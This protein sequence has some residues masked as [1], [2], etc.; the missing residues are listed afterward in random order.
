MILNSENHALSPSWWENIEQHER[1]QIIYALNHK[2]HIMSNQTSS[3]HND[4]I[5]NVSGWSFADILTNI[6][7]FKGIV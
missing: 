6:D 3:Q 7:W 4:D 5:P 2:L 1:S